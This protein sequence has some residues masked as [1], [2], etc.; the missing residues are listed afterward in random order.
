[1]TTRQILI[2]ITSNKTKNTNGNPT[3][4][5]FRENSYDAANILVRGSDNHE[6]HFGCYLKTL[7]SDEGKVLEIMTVEHACAL[8][9]ALQIAIDEN[10]LFTASQ[11]KEGKTSATTTRRKLIENLK[12]K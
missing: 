8:M 1:M 3:I 12:S 2:D 10:W 4:V 11:I 7:S 5:F 6:G 9:E